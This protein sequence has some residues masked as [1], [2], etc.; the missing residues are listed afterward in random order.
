MRKDKEIIETDF[1]KA[2]KWSEGKFIENDII[3][4]DN[5]KK[6]QFPKDSRRMSFILM[7]LCTNGQVEYNMDT[8]KQVLK[9]GQVILV[10]E[11]HVIDGYNA[12]PDFEGICFMISVPFYNEIMRN[13]SD[14]SAMY[15]FAHNHPI[16]ELEPHDQQTFKDYFQVVKSKI[17]ENDNRFRRD[18]VRTLILA[19]FYDLSNVIYRFHQIQEGRITRADIIFTQFIKLVE[20]NCRTERRVSW[21]A[22]ELCITPKYLSEMVKHVSKRTPNSWIDAYVT[23]ELRVILKNSTK[24]I[25]E[26]AKEMNFP[27]QSFLGKY[28]K[29]HVGM[30]PSKFRRSL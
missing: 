18:L 7:G 29:E 1:K 16:F 13:V 28:F 3:L 17:V 23:L 21:Y 27:N 12:S 14:V 11:R 26:I 15:L 8:K 25:K 30:S 10:S 5:F 19:M 6:I 24:S 22:H 4:L 9:P 2:T 20:E